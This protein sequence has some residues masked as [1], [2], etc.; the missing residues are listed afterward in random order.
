MKVRFAHIFVCICCLVLVS[1]GCASVQKNYKE[2]S[3]KF[4]P[5]V[6]ADIGIFADTT[7]ALITDAE[8]GLTSKKSILVRDLM[9]LE[10]NE[11][12]SLFATRKKVSGALK[13][14]VQYSVDLVVITETNET[15]AKMI[16]A[17]ADYLDG[18]K[19]RAVQNLG[20]NEAHYDELIEKIRSQE[21]FLGAMQRAQPII[22]AVSQYINKLLEEYD[23]SI[24]ALFFKID[25]KIDDRYREVVWYQ[26]TLETEKYEILKALGMVYLTIKGDTGAYDRLVDS[27]IILQEQLLPKG[28]PSIKELSAIADHLTQRLK[29]TRLIG[30]KNKTGAYFKKLRRKLIN[31]IP[32]GRA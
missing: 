13:R 17:Y 2:Y 24:D 15:E 30:L 7:I 25:A 3:K 4:S 12:K 14:I 31:I 6:Q 27:G 26:Q 9:E 1:S 18:F 28:K 19:Q 8:L 32:F 21:T 22:N 5:Q 23:D 20:Y 10:G 16:G 29:S 11:E